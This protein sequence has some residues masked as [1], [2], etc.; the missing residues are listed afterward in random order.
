M[1]DFTHVNWLFSNFAQKQAKIRIGKCRAG[2]EGVL[3]RYQN[4]LCTGASGSFS[5]LMLL[6]CC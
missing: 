3:F 5:F 1:E 6:T 2:N 4:N